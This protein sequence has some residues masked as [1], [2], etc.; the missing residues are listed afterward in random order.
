MIPCEKNKTAI[1]DF[2]DTAATKVLVALVICIMRTETVLV[3]YIGCATE[4]CGWLRMAAD[5]VVITLVIVLSWG[6]WSKRPFHTT[7]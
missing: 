5:K 3:L 7:V 4:R 1:A 6:Y 2:T